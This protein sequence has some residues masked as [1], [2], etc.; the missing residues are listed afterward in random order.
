M[1]V[2]KKWY[3]YIFDRGDKKNNDIYAD[4]DFIKYSPTNAAYMLLPIYPIFEQLYAICWK[5]QHTQANTNRGLSRS[6]NT[7]LSKLYGTALSVT[8]SLMLVYLLFRET[9]VYHIDD[10]I[11]RERSFCNISADNHLAAGRPTRSARRWCIL[12]DVLLL[13]RRQRGVEWINHNGT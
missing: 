9:R 4:I 11:N 5:Y 8:L 10:P 12:K 1:D 7:H 2:N 3:K 6:C 13:A